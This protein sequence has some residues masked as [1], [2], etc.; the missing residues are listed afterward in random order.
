MAAKIPPQQLEIE[1]EKALK[2]YS[3]DVAEKVKKEVKDA[4][5][6]GVKKLKQTSPKKT[7]EYAKGWKYKVAY[8]NSENIRVIIYNKNKPQLTHLLE[9]GHAK[10]KGGRVEGIP[11]IRPVEKEIEKEIGEKVKVVVRT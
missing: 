9:N 7:G 6:N 1:I 10:A 2:N 4:A 3:A 8:E 5:K 11:H